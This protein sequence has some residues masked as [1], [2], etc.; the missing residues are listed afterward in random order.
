MGLT[1]HER[2]AITNEL[3]ER[4]QIDPSKFR[5]QMGKEAMERLRI[6]WLEQTALDFLLS[7][8]KI[9]E[10]RVKLNETEPGEVGE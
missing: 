7:G 2:K 8:T 1:M 4:Y 6:Q 3:A 10:K 9:K 5:D